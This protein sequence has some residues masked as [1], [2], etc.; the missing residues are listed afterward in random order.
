MINEEQAKILKIVRD[1]ELDTIQN[2]YSFDNLC[3]A[4]FISYTGA[5]I[6]FITD[7]GLSALE[8]YERAIQ[9]SHA[10]DE[11]IRLSKRSNVISICSL[12][13]SIVAIVVAALV[14]IYY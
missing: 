4:G 1:E 6:A 14:G 12:I 11:S 10:R 2:F 8:E 9:D 7:S 5:G 13:L 3:N